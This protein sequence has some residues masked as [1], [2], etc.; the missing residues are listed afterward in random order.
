[1]VKVIQS[2]YEQNY[3]LYRDISFWTNVINIPTFLEQQC[4]ITSSMDKSTQYMFWIIICVGNVCVTK[5][6]FN[7]LLKRTW[8]S[9]LWICT[10]FISR[11]T[12]HK[13]FPTSMK[14]QFS[15]HML[16]FSSSHFHTYL[17]CIMNHNE[18]L[19]CSWCPWLVN[20]LGGLRAHTQPSADECEDSCQTAHTFILYSED[21]TS[22]WGNKMFLSGG[23]FSNFTLFLY[24]LLLNRNH[25]FKD[26]HD[27]ALK[28]NF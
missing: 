20:L 15:V 17:S 23:G 27:W 12:G 7:I 2:F 18:V 24:L 25:E 14:H 9:I 10:I 6:P 22:K 21:L 4:H 1:M 8:R 19:K 5:N 26:H 3:I 11:L 13:S 28:S 16:E